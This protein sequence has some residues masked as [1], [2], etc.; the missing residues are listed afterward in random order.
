MVGHL[1]HNPK[2]KGLNPASDTTREKRMQKLFYLSSTVAEYFAHNHKIKGLNPA[3][4]T[5]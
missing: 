3:A 4:G 2:V 1:A 5:G